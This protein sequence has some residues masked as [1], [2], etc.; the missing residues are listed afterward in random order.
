M[1]ESVE[2][3]FHAVLVAQMARSP[4]CFTAVATGSGITG[5]K[6]QF[7][8]PVPPQCELQVFL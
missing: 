6:L 3:A 2:A 7:L 8:S 4:S 1:G 5:A